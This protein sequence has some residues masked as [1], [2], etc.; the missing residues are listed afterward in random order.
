M[1]LQEEISYMQQN[2]PHLNEYIHELMEDKKREGFLEA[3]TPS[4]PVFNDDD[5]MI[6]N[7]SSNLSDSQDE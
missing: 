7:R 2:L 6:K 4:L 1:T 3:M 5:E